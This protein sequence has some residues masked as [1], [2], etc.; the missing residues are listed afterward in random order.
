MDTL[1]LLGKQYD[2][3][4]LYVDNLDLNETNQCTK[5]IKRLGGMNNL[6]NI[7]SNKIN[8]QFMRRGL[9]QAYIVSEASKSSRTSFVKTIEKS[10]FSSDDCEIVNEKA[11]WLHICYL[12]D[13]EDYPNIK[14]I[15]VP[16]SIDFCTNIPRKEFLTIMK[17]SKVIFDSRER[18][19][20]YN[21]VSI[22]TPIVF[23]DEYG[24]EVLL[25]AETIFKKSMVPTMGLNVNGAGDIYALLFILRNKDHSIT[26]SATKAMEDTTKK[27]IQRGK[28]EKI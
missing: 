23:H 15:R 24:V 2:D 26:D 12:D 5:V 1:F 14:N 9:K 10:V 8:L 6:E 3:I 17:K 11:D 19:E 28:S 21:N 13:I 20:L 18:K 22:D 16:F 4:I 27:L 7:S 25:K